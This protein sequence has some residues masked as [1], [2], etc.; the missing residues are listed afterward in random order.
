MDFNSIAIIPLD[1]YAEL[2][3][4]AWN[5]PSASFKDRVGTTAQT[6]VFCAIV[7]AG[8]VAGSWGWAKAMEWREAK[9]FERD[10]R[11]I[12]AQEVKVD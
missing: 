10:M 4:T 7:T 8:V 9:A 12:E 6:F 11:K 1:E 2:Q 5:L 3:S